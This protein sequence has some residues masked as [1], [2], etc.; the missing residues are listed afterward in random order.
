VTDLATTPASASGKPLEEV[1]A[2]RLQFEHKL[3]ADRMGWLLTLNGFLVTSAAVLAANGDKFARSGTLSAAL[4]AVGVL[5]ATSNASCLFSNYWGTRAIRETCVVLVA[6]WSDVADDE[7]EIR[8]TRMRLYGRD[9]RAAHDLRRSPPSVLFH[10]WLMLP[11]VFGAFFTALPYFGAAL[12]ADD[13]DLVWW[14]PNLVLTPFLVLVVLAVLDA[15]FHLRRHACAF[16]RTHAD[17]LGFAGRRPAW[18][19]IRS[20]YVAERRLV[21]A[22]CVES[23][24]DGV[25]GCRSWRWSV[26]P[27]ETYAA[28]Q[29]DARQ[30]VRRT[31]G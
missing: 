7:R 29:S 31:P 30:G 27:D 19:E 26:I 4:L 17:A 21:R 20:R 5:G 6:S 2:E 15:R 24:P 14:A 10:P 13:S 28:Y 8:R 3:I 18:R 1:F 12:R 16:A 22:W 11:L 25:P 9:P 23:E